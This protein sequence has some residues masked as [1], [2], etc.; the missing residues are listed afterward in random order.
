MKKPIAVSKEQLL[1]FTSTLGFANNRP[2]P[3]SVRHRG[4]APVLFASS[5]DLP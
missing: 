5:G 3:Q 2:V 4:P 1:A